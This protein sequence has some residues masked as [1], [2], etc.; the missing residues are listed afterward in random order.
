MSFACYLCAVVI[1]EYCPLTMRKINRRKWLQKGKSFWSNWFRIRIHH[2]AGK[3]IYVCMCQQR[4]SNGLAK[5]IL[6]FRSEL[7]CIEIGQMVSKMN[8]TFFFRFAF[9][10][11]QSFFSVPFAIFQETEMEV[12][13]FWCMFGRNCVHLFQ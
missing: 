7:I 11:T 5:W 13:N 4:K 6:S 10:R 9:F 3:N 1:S 2:E 12:S 8:A